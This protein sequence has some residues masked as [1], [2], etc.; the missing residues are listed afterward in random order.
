MD[1]DNNPIAEALAKLI[2]ELLDAGNLECAS[3]AFALGD[4]M[5]LGGEVSDLLHYNA[6]S[7]ISAYDEYKGK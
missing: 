5:R 1:L 6:M 4:S 2:E 7:L 3:N